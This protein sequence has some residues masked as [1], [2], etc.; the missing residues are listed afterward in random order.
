MVSVVAIPCG[1]EGW[2]GFGPCSTAGK[3]QSAEDYRLLVLHKGSEQETT[4][5]CGSGSSAGLCSP[6]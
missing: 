2:Q 5:G 4:P 3:P 1:L 6:V